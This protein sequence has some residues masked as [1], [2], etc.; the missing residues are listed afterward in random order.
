MMTPEEYQVSGI[1]HLTRLALIPSG[2]VRS[3]RSEHVAYHIL[4]YCTLYN[5]TLHCFTYSL[6]LFPNP[7]RQDLYY[8]SH[9]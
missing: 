9:T 3:G 8:K 4:A 5:L 1:V 2:M 6:N 7:S